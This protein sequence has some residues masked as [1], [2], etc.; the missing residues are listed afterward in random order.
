MSSGNQS[1]IK[2]VINESLPLVLSSNRES[3]FSDSSLAAVGSLIKLS[4]STDT[5]IQI[6]SV[7]ISDEIATVTNTGGN[8]WES[9]YIMTGTEPDGVITFR[10]DLEDIHGNPNSISDNTTNGT[11]VVFDNSKPSLSYVNIKSSNQDSTLARV[12]DTIIIKFKGDELL[13]GQSAT[14]LLNSGNIFSDNNESDIIYYA[15]YILKGDDPEGDVNFEIIVTDSVGI[16]SNPVIETTNGSS[17]T[18]DRTLP[19]ISNLHIESNNNNDT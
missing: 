14:I 10:M 3:D 19:V 15:K 12:G 8:N 4:F 7:L 2:L 16:Q 6:P 5:E 11:S 13:T 9:T 17:V 18:F 1:L